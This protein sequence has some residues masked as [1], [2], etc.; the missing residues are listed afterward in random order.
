MKRIAT[1]ALAAAV[2]TLILAGLTPLAAGDFKDEGLA[3]LATLEKK[4]VGLA[5]A[6]PAEKYTWRPADGARSVSELFLHAAGANFGIPRV[7]GTPPPAGFDF[8]GYE[9]QTTAKADVVKRLTASFQHVRTAVANLNAADADKP[10][11]M[12]GSDTTMRG[13]VLNMLEHLS[14]HLGNSITYARVNGVTP[15]WNER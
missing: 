14:E 3:R 5:E 6:I 7:I 2:A 9:T 1:P 4:Y 8:K 15:P 10:V 13:A 11:K 12:F